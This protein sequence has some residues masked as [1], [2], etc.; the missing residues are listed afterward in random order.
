M[1]TL[2]GIIPN[3]LLVTLDDGRREKFV[4][5]GRGEWVVKIRAAMADRGD[6]S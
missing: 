1:L 6:R 2:P 5:N 3:G 4:V